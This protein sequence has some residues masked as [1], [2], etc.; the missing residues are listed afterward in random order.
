MKTLRIYTAIAIFLVLLAF[1]LISLEFYGYMDPWAESVSATLNLIWVFSALLALVA[2]SQLLRLYERGDAPRRIWA[3][4][5]LGLLLRLGGEIS[6]FVLE[7]VM[8]IEVPYPSIADYFWLASYIPML[9]AMVLLVWGYR[10][11]HLTFRKWSLVVVI[12]LI[13]II[14]VLITIFV[15]LPIVTNADAP[16]ADKVF[17]PAYMYLDFLIIVPALLITFAFSKARQGKPW[18]L[19]SYAFMF[20]AVFDTVAAYLYAN[21]L[22]STGNYIN[23]MWVSGYVMIAIAAAYQMYLIQEELK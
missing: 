2:V 23:L 6:Y 1:I 12:P 11:L 4:I 8:K 9:A 17:N 22:Y 3:L 13:L 20:F 19:I 10:K 5:W 16:L 7:S 14:L 18:Q 21:D 15:A